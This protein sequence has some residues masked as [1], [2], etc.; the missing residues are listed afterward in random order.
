MESN[1][2]KVRCVECEY[3]E[4][5]YGAVDLDGLPIMC[6]CKKMGIFNVIQEKIQCD[7]FS[8]KQKIY[9]EY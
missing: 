1:T 8:K 6:A 7:S 3:S 4:P 9:D 5:Y 2:N